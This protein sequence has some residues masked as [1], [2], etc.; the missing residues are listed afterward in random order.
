M[1]VYHANSREEEEFQEWCQDMNEALIKCILYVK[2][3]ESGSTSES[4]I[5]I[6]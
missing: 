4:D 1:T 6:Y 2:K 5:L 3:K